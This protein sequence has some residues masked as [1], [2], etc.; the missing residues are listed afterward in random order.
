MKRGMRR[1]GGGH[2]TATGMRLF[3]LAG[4]VLLLGLAVAGCSRGS[5]PF[6]IFQEMHYQPSFR[7]QEPDRLDVPAEAVPR[8]MLDRGSTG[9]E[10]YA[11]N[12]A[13]CHGDTGLGD[14]PA[15]E[16]IVRKY[17]YP[18]KVD[19]SL[20]GDILE[21][22]SDAALEAMIAGG[23]DLMPPFEKLLSEE[24]RRLIVEYLRQLP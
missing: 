8:A 21:H 16:A 10:L 13:M 5:Y 11:V 19:P 9:A 6:D 24:E 4:L 18:P 7:S 22:L 1:Q 14:G 12:C 15:L 2:A 23:I 20:A 17:G 3:G